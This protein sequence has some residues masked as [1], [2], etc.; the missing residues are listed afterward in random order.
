MA[1]LEHTLAFDD[2]N[3]AEIYMPRVRIE[4]T[5]F[6]LW[7]WRA[8]YCANEAILTLQN[9]QYL[10]GKRTLSVFILCKSECSKIFSFC[11]T[12]L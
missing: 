12:F 5:T 10:K 3:A 2:K 4:L 7:D 9:W 8:A 1:R 6:R 11:K